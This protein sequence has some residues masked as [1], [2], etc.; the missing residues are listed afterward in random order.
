[1]AG[2]AAASGRAAAGLSL[3]AASDLICHGAGIP[4]S[5]ADR[6]ARERAVMTIRAR[7][8]GTTADAAWSTGNGMTLEKAIA[9]AAEQLASLMVPADAR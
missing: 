7:L 2:L 6:N 9:Y 5:A 8:D 3:L 4:S 1:M